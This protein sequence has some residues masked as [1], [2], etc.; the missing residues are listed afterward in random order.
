MVQKSGQR[1]RV[2]AFLRGAVLEDFGIEKTLDIA[3]VPLGEQQSGRCVAKMRKLLERLFGEFARFGVDDAERSDT[4]S[5][6]R[7]KDATGVG[8]YA[9]VAG[10]ERICAKAR[11]LG[12]I[13]DDELLV[14]HDRVGAESH[15]APGSP[16]AFQTDIRGESLLGLPDERDQRDRGV[17]DPGG[18]LGQPLERM[19]RCFV[20][21][22]QA[23]QQLQA[24]HFVLGFRVRG[25]LH[26]G[27]FRARC[28]PVLLS[29][30]VL[31]TH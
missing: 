24:I 25:R 28:Y 14:V 30:V 8:S 20:V 21:D 27:H 22:A 13:G 23:V 9:R 18:H 2:R 15:V 31:T 17:R 1:V 7:L 4:L 16:D 19:E 12:G 6:L 11:V 29:P 5:F 26:G 10:D 3:A